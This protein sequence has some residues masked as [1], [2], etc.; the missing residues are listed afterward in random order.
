MIGCRRTVAVSVEENNSD[1]LHYNSFGRLSWG[2]CSGK[3]GQTQ[4]S[5][6]TSYLDQNITT[7]TVFS[8]VWFNIDY[9]TD[10]LC[11][12]LNSLE[13]HTFAEL[14]INTVTGKKNGI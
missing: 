11:R 3:G 2:K 4:G 10:L 1:Y 8:H 12:S 9:W 5:A 13:F 6:L 7:T 14:H